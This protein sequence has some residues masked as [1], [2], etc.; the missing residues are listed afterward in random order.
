MNDKIARGGQTEHDM[1]L[2]SRE[3]GE[4]K[5]GWEIKVHQNG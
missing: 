3:L 4:R 1:I 5:R 2:E